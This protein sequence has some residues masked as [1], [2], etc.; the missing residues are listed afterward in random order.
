MIRLES[1]NI[2]QLRAEVVADLP[3]G[4]WCV[5]FDQRV[6]YCDSKF[7]EI[8]GDGQ[9]LYSFEQLSQL[10][11][12]DYKNVV[13][14]MFGEMLDSGQFDMVFPLKDKWVH[15]HLIRITPENQRAIGYIM[16]AKDADMSVSA[17]NEEAILIATKTNQLMQ[18]IFD[19]MMEFDSE[20]VLN[21]ILAELLSFLGADRISMLKY[22]DLKDNMT[23]THGVTRYGVESRIGVLKDLTPDSIPWLWNNIEAGKMTIIEDVSKLSSDS[24]LEVDALC[25]YNAKTMV[26]HPLKIKDRVAGFFIIDYIMSS[27]VLRD[28][29]KSSIRV[30]GECIEFVLYVCEKEVKQMSEREQLSAVVKNVPLGYLSLRVIYNQD[31]TSEALM[32]SKAN[33]AFERMVQVEGLEGKMMS[34]I[35]GKEANHLMEVCREVARNFEKSTSKI[36][37]DFLYCN[38]VSL[39]AMVMMAGYNEFVC[40]ATPT[41]SLLYSMV[42]DL[43]SGLQDHTLS[44]ELQHKIRTYL[45]T[46]VGFSELL[47]DE[48]DGVVKDE[49]IKIIKDNAE[50]L[51]N[52]TN[53]KE[54]SD[55]ESQKTNFSQE[56]IE[57]E[58]EK[59]TILVAED[60]ESNYM[61]VS[62]I[63]KSQYNLVWAHDGIEALE[64]YEKTKPDLILMDVRMPRLGGL[65]ATS[66][67]REMDKTTPII[68]LTAFAFES[69]KSKTLEAG[70]TDF[71]SKPI[72]VSVLKS[73]VGKYLKK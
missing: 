57:K 47:K 35:V 4:L 51:I 11:R 40:F 29:E 22:D 32:I 17:D 7:G 70:C 48:N 61:L 50:E 69:D 52:V 43:S 49:Y 3:F 41:S 31:N 13:M 72:N 66:K 36:V 10:I 67:I 23:C 24:L 26:M 37:D 65:S 33:A 15:V 21:D 55:M 60:T 5:N 59:P 9:T 25:N 8:V 27:H 1:I 12:P 44:K 28:H 6:M 71:L 64:L 68:A 58:V 30:L 20:D 42:H 39:S 56:G 53:I 62:Y 38:G 19:K 73:T 63:L 14:M 16:E 45:N 34:E 46:I 54:D 2:E 18:K